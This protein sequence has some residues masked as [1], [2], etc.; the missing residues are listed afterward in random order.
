MA[1][2]SHAE[3]EVAAASET[4]L[5]TVTQT[6][7]ELKQASGD[8]WLRTGR[9]RREAH[10]AETH[11]V[12]LLLAIVTGPPSKAVENVRLYRGLRAVK[13]FHETHSS[14]T[15]QGSR[16][17]IVTTQQDTEG[18]LFSG[19]TLGADLDL[20]IRW[21]ADPQHAEEV[22][23]LRQNGA[24]V[25]ITTGRHPQAQIRLRN[26]LLDG[27]DRITEYRQVLETPAGQVLNLQQA[28]KQFSAIRYT[29]VIELPLL[30]CL[31]ALWRSSTERTGTAAPPSPSGS[32]SPASDAPR[33]RERRPCKG[34]ASPATR[35]RSQC[36]LDGTTAPY[37][38]G[39]E[40]GKVRAWHPS[41]S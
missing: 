19:G 38:R 39:G 3:R 9:G 8:L 6:A 37:P 24:E 20:F 28:G 36:S 1:S 16:G 4:P 2:G 18:Q 13:D 15:P 31:A 14:L 30:E 34:G 10:V 33:K 17:H 35:E 29:A 40:R 21:L 23:R 5:V 11:L 27:K 25:T 7:R 26:L 12:N 22:A 41:P 32:T